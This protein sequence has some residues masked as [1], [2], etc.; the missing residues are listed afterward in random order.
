MLVLILPADLDATYHPDL[1][2][3]VFVKE[4]YHFSNV[5]GIGMFIVYDTFDCALECLSNPSCLSLNLAASKGADGKFW[6]EL[7]TSGKYINPCEYKE[8][9][10]SHHFFLKV[11][12]I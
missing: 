3:N 8:N 12:L 11:G 4:E 2:Q 6:C 10:T 9:K 1:R 7:L 5:S